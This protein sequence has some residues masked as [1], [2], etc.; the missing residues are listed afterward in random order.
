[1][2]SDG[3]SSSMKRVPVTGLMPDCRS[4]GVVYCVGA[5]IVHTVHLH[6]GVCESGQH[7]VA[8]LLAWLW[9]HS[10]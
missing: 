8:R 4:C 10:V 2:L 3:G 5:F 9:R 6:V 7:I 1:M